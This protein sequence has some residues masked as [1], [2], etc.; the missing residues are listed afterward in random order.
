MQSMRNINLNS[1]SLRGLYWNNAKV[2]DEIG[3]LVH[4]TR[5]Q[6]LYR[7]RTW[8]SVIS[9]D[10]QESIRI[11]LE[12]MDV[13]STQG[14]NWSVDALAEVLTQLEA[15]QAME[16]YVLLADLY[17]LQLAS[18]LQDIQAVLVMLDIPLVKE[19]W[20]EANLAV[21]RKDNPELTQA[22]QSYA[23]KMKGDAPS[24]CFVEPTST[25][26]FT[27][28]IQTGEK[29]WYLHSNRNPVEEA[30]IW[31]RRHYRL[32]KEAYTVYGWA[33]GYHIRELL[34]NDEEMDLVVLEPDIEILYY[35]FS[36]GDWTYELQRIT[37]IWDPNWEKTRNYISENREFLVYRPE[38]ANVEDDTICALLS[39][40]AERKDS[41]LSNERI[42]YQNIRDN[43]RNCED[44]VDVIR[45]RVKGKR[46]VIVAGGPSLD[47]NLDELKGKPEDV[48]VIAVGTVYKL[49]LKKGIPIDYVAFLDAR[50]FYQINEVQSYKEALLI[51]ATADRRIGRYYK[52][53]KYLVCQEGHE[54]AAD[55][56]K[57]RGYTCYSSGGSVAT[58][59]LDIAIR[60]G[61]ASIAFIGL[62]L[63]Y[64]G[65]RMHASGTAREQF[66][67]F[68][69]Q[70]ALAWDGS[71]LNTSQTFLRFR[72]W[73]EERIQQPDATMTIVDATEGGIV[74]NGFQPMTLKAYLCNENACKL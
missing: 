43:I 15:A 1:D 57:E 2:L 17:E 28:G 70:K 9:R 42:F 36:C 26:Y 67:G 5:E 10:L 11:I 12:N 16:D 53:K 69:L 34:Q 58:M 19:E 64:Y 21:L 14:L 62:D 38:L 68:Q 30:R 66:G 55:Y 31:A 39:Q 51:L 20:W 37:L 61:A 3:Q 59:A 6:N 13:F 48:V 74:K 65:T 63:A 44:Y 47:K 72:T 4:V 33:M 60:M 49:L 73:L 46:V 24:R 25:G 27:M 40:M 22:L 54:L 8:I 41:I 35:A 52:G 18:M 32:A 50:V 23:Q 7:I 71:E 45:D 29:T 56:A